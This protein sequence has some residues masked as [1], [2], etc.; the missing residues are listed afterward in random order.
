MKPTEANSKTRF[1]LQSNREVKL[2]QQLQ[3]NFSKLYELLKAPSEKKR[4][5]RR[6]KQRK[7]ENEK[8]DQYLSYLINSL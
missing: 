4:K 6:T 7:E 8:R 1:K 3:Q 2:F 5:L